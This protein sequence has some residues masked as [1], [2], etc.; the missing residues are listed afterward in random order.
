M[1]SH[2]IQQIGLRPPPIDPDVTKII[3]ECRRKQRPRRGYSQRRLFTEIVQHLAKSD[4]KIRSVLKTAKEL[5]RARA[6]ALFERYRTPPPPYPAAGPVG[7]IGGHD[8]TEHFEPPIHHVLGR[9]VRMPDYAVDLEIGSIIEYNTVACDLN[10]LYPRWAKVSG[11][12]EEPQDQKFNWYQ[13][14]NS[15][16]VSCVAATIGAGVIEPCS[17]ANTATWCWDFTGEQREILSPAVR[18]RILGPCFP[19][20]AGDPEASVTLWLITSLTI[21]KWVPPASGSGWKERVEIAKVGEDIV[22]SFSSDPDMGD[23]KPP[24][25]YFGGSRDAGV[26]FQPSQQDLLVNVEQ[27]AEYTVELGVTI[28]LQANY[29]SSIAV[30]K[31]VVGD[32]LD[33]CQ[34]KASCTL[35][36]TWESW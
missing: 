33:P 5:D 18:L 10:N 21:V 25:G 24:E 26:P 27:G 34:L 15:E 20:V 36:K 23:V 6:K 11:T 3:E 14:S 16:N 2:A 22:L 35:W 32:Y 7:P 28:N 1:K 19:E 12:G 13:W 8:W 31:Y 9:T 29:D 4:S 17:V 30:G